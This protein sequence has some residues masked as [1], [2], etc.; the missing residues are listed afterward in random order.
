MNYFD[1]FI[2][3]SRET[4]NS[5]L[6]EFSRPTIRI[7]FYVSLCECRNTEMLKSKL[8]MLDTI[9]KLGLKNDFICTAS[10]KE[11][12]ELLPKKQYEFLSK[13]IYNLSKNLNVS[14][15]EEL[16]SLRSLV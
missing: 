10:L 9:D 3:Y 8:D 13:G 11:L 5:L 12:Y 7:D 16:Y 4:L 15:N 2:F 1:E 6:H 14:N